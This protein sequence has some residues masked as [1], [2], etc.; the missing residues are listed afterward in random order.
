[1]LTRLSV[2]FSTDVIGLGFESAMDCR[3]FELE[4][5]NGWSVTGS[6]AR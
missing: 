1:M 3:D 6:R 5:T 2:M 4:Q